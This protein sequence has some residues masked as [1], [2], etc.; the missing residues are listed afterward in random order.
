MNALQGAVLCSDGE[1]FSRVDLHEDHLWKH[2]E[3]GI[4]DNFSEHS[5]TAEAKVLSANTIG[6]KRKQVSEAQTH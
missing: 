6:D 1:G 2:V 3:A 4:R 5:R